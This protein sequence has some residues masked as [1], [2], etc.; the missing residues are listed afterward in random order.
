MRRLHVRLG[1]QTAS[2]SFYPDG[3]VA[4]VQTAGGTLANQRLPSDLWR[5]FGSLATAT[6]RA[7]SSLPLVDSSLQQVDRHAGRVDTFRHAS[8]QKAP[9]QPKAT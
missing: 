5:L 2:E 9:P 6:W 7:E 1:T 3:R 8:S 4:E